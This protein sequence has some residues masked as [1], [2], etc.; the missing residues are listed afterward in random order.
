[1]FHAE[2][3]ALEVDRE[4]A[5]PRLLR[6]LDHAADLDDADIVVEHVDAPV[7]V[8]ASR[9]RALHVRRARRV[10]PERFGV[11][12]LAADDLHGFPRGGF[13]QVDAEH[14]R[15]FARE[16]HGGGLAVAPAG[17]DRARADDERRLAGEPSCH[18]PLPLSG[19]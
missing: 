12:A 5:V 16:Q 1:V 7:S 15:A 4:D 9:D 2:K 8:E 18:V 14:A 3:A 11:T 17:T 6:E 10:G 13:V 19:A